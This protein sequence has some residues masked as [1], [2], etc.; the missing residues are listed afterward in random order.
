MSVHAS[1]AELDRRTDFFMTPK[2]RDFGGKIKFFQTAPGGSGKLAGYSWSF[3]ELLGVSRNDPGTILG[4]STFRYFLQIFVM[5]G[6]A[7]S[8]KTDS[9]ARV[10]TAKTR[11]PARECAWSP[12]ESNT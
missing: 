1:R 11:D 7:V 8:F 12:H 2:C 9:N 3:H 5:F 4:C 6:N 10:Y